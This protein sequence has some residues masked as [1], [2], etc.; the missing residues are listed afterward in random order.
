[1]GSS[2][3]LN[4]KLTA[5]KKVELRLLLLVSLQYSMKPGVVKMKIIGNHGE[6]E[7]IG[8]QQRENQRNLGSS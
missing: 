4:K 7:L 6:I 3:R 1:V 2:L 5:L 8:T